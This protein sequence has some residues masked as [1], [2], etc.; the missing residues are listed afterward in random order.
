MSCFDITR[1]V[2]ILAHVPVATTA[3]AAATGPVSMSLPLVV[4]FL[5]TAAVVYTLGRCLVLY[6]S[7]PLYVL[8]VYRVPVTGIK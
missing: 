1:R 5:G 3:R 2:S 7:V 8:R 6:Y 4:V